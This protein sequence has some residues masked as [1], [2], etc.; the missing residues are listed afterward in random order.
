MHMRSAST[1]VGC[2]GETRMDQTLHTRS[3][4]AGRNALLWMNGV[5]LALL[6][7]FSLVT[8]YSSDD[9][10]YSTFW[11]NGLGHYLELME[12][13]YRSFNGRTVVHV[14]AHVV[15]HFGGW[16]F[17]LV[18]CGLCVTSAWLAAKADGLERGRFRA[19]LFVVLIGI[20]SMPL[21][22]FNQG[23]MWVSAFCN[24]LFPV[25]MACLLILALERGSS[26]VFLPAFL[27]G[28]STEQMGLAAVALCGI[29]TV[30]AL[31]H[32]RGAWR[33]AAS[34]LMAIGGV[35]TIFLSPATRLRAERSV[36]LDSLAQ[37]LELL[38]KD[39]LLEAELLTANPA[40]V[41]VMLAVLGLGALLLW[42]REGLK[43]PAI[44]SAVGCVALIA[45]SFGSEPVCIAGFIV[46]FAALAGVGWMLLTRGGE[47]I[48][49]MILTALAAAAVMLPTDTIEPR[50]M[51]P[52]YLL[53]LLA[54]G[55]L[56]VMQ[57]PKVEQMAVPAAVVLAVTIVLAIPAV[58]GYWYNY[59]IDERNKA[60]AREDAQTP[61]V[62]Y[63]LDYDMDYT[64]SKADFD[65]YFRSKYAQSI[66]LPETTPIRFFSD[67]A[68]IKPVYCG[69]TELA[70]LS[71]CGEDG[72]VFF[73]LRDVIEIMGGALDWYGSR[74]TLKFNGT[75]YALLR[76]GEDALHVT[77]TDAHGA[78]REA[79]GVCM[80]H[81]GSTFCDSTL[82]VE[83]LGFAIQWDEQE[84]YYRITK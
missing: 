9:Y 10:W 73:P 39:I 36:P 52:V 12:F 72:T 57:L 83:G 50:V 30:L 53:L 17:A 51:L 33:Y 19:L 77:W 14:L 45:G 49:A 69:D 1:A 66:G 7:Y 20:F 84:G 31:A 3:E 6:A 81:C 38:R 68:P 62:R 29:Y 42:N 27:C 59:Q 75:E 56:L 34:M 2:K 63:C 24:Y 18:C 61:F 80:I 4:R 16:L 76:S 58:R 13:H 79:Q 71:V 65:G 22:M 15:L 5:L 25:T 64:W 46:G 54:G 44:L 67:H 78:E 32:R 48:G 40:P 23:M 21:D 47:A 82:F 26:W 28:A 8:V 11:D 41:L 35:L 74:M 55:C 37:I 70:L 43:W 60:Y